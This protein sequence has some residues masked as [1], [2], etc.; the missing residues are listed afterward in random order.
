MGHTQMHRY[1]GTAA[2]AQVVQDEDEKPQAAPEPESP[3]RLVIKP[4]RDRKVHQQH[5]TF[6]AFSV[7]LPE[8]GSENMRLLPSN[9]SDYTARYCARA[10]PCMTSAGFRGCMSGTA[11]SSVYSHVHSCIPFSSTKVHYVSNLVC[12]LQPVT[13]WHWS[14]CSSALHS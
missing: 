8:L 7:V 2:V 4:R 13:L 6:R 5:G 3:P 11:L 1:A 14:Q 9:V 10:C 12:I